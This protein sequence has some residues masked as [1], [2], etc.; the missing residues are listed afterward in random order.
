ML[1]AEPGVASARLMLLD[2]VA[3]VVASG[4]GLLGVNAPASM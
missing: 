4:L 3:D 2:C 1:S